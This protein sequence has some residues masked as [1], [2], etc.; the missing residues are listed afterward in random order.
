MW[1]FPDKPVY[2]GS[3]PNPP[4]SGT[5]ASARSGWCLGGSQPVYVQ[6]GSDSSFPAVTIE[7]SNPAL[8][9]ATGTGPTLLL[10]VP[11]GAKKY[12]LWVSSAKSVVAGTPVNVIPFGFDVPDAGAVSGDTLAITPAWI[13]VGA[14]PLPAGALRATLL[15]TFE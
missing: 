14:E 12:R 9:A 5:A 10:K 11:A 13:Q 4:T 1:P 6:Q 2:S 15:V 7:L 8:G 3:E